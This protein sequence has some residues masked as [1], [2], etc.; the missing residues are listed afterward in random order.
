MNGVRRLEEESPRK[1]LPIRALGV[2]PTSHSRTP[3][4]PHDGFIFSSV[5]PT[6]HSRPIP[7]GTAARH[8]HRHGSPSAGPA[9]PLPVAPSLTPL[10]RCPGHGDGLRPR[11]VYSP[12]W[13]LCMRLRW[14]ATRERS[15][16]RQIA[17][18]AAPPPPWRGG[19]AGGVRGSGDVRVVRPHG[20]AWRPALS[21]PSPLPSPPLPNHRRWHGLGRRLGRRQSR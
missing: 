7:T 5:T 16:A 18:A 12:C 9:S 13:S 14:R 11:A 21:R 20:Y 6:S 1:N 17:R 3:P 8:W 2:A 10:S 4:N 19:A 15:G